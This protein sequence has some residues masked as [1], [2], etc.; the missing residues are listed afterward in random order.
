MAI[1]IGDLAFVYSDQ[2]MA[3]A[4]PTAWRIWNELRIELNVGQ[5]LDSGR[6]VAAGCLNS[7]AYRE[8]VR[9]WATAAVET[10]ADRI[11]WDEPHWAHPAHFDEPL[12]RC[13]GGATSAPQQ[14][15]KETI[16]IFRPFQLMMPRCHGGAPVISCGVW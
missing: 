3:G 4:N 15:S 6:P 8:F 12:E 16:G 1:L 9:S 14:P 11:F 13:E 7:E 5:V 2:L 10:G